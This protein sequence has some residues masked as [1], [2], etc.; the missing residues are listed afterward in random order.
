MNAIEIVGAILL[1]LSCL[2]IIGVVLMQESN[3]GNQNSVIQGSSDSYYGRN[4]GR[5]LDATLIKVTRIA[6]IVFVV[7]TIVVNLIAV[8]SK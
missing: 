2:V 4:K 5:T 8:F 6:A 3:Q 1:V 7:I